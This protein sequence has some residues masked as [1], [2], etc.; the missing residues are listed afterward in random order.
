MK[1]HEIKVF[2]GKS[3]SNEDQ[4]FNSRL[5]RY[6][7]ALWYASKAKGHLRE[8]TKLFQT[9]RYPECVSA[10]GM[11]IEF[12]LKAICAFL[13]ADFKAEHDLSRPLTHLSVKLPKY[14]NELSRAAWISSRWVG[15]NQQTRLLANYGNQDAAVPA[16]K[17]IGRKDVTLIK[18]DGYEACN[19][20]HFVETRQKFC[21]PRK[22]GILNGF[23]DEEDPA[24][25][26]CEKYPFSE[27][28]TGDWEASFSKIRVS[29]KSKFE[30]EKIPLSKVGGEYAVI[31]NPFGEAYPEKDVRSRF[32]FN[33]LKNYVEDGGVLVNV[34][35]F[36][37][38]YAWDVVKGAEEPVVDEKTLVPQSV[39]TEGGK[40]YVDRFALFVNFAGSLSW[41]ELGIITTSDTAQMSGPN[42]LEVFQ[43][44][45]DRKIAGD[46][47][48]TGGKNKVY[49]FRSI[50]KGST[51][52]VI[53]LLRAN[54]PDFGEV[55]PIAA[56]KRG[57][58][59]MVLGGMSTKGA[60]ELEKLITAVDNFCDW[61]QKS[62]QIA[63]LT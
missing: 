44:E 49:E 62:S 3:L 18:S 19:L 63:K 50:P 26:P 54:R 32:G 53:P 34:A 39:R 22:M 12:S 14:S 37:F 10:F 7:L 5:P 60:S 21:T 58:G 20:L 28:R 47:V 41:R 15:A 31:I 16:T 27:F 17:F 25:K 40:L 23:V 33:H 52:D 61:M 59:Y 30:V 46:I 1:Q 51:K 45:D 55:Y 24:E 42:E 48:N 4:M 57:F 35:G 6:D 29:E 2:L 9:F 43:E 13:G 8:G 36:P 11:S 56:V 38:F